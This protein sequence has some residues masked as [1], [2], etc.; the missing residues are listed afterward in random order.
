MLCSIRVLVICMTHGGSILLNPRMNRKICFVKMLNTKEWA[1]YLVE[2]KIDFLQNMTC[3]LP[4]PEANHAFRLMRG[5]SR[6]PSCVMQITDY[7]YPRARILVRAVVRSI[8]IIR[9]QIK[10][11]DYF[12]L[13]E[14]GANWDTGLSRTTHFSEYQLLKINFVIDEL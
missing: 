13:G 8:S 6:I 11:Y 10:Q 1:R 14:S 2:K 5:F 7:P 4:S 12:K 3:S 9:Y